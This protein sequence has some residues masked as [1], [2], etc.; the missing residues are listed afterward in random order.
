[1]RIADLVIAHP[2]HM[3]EPQWSEQPNGIVGNTAAKPVTGEAERFFSR[4]IVQLTFCRV[5]C[6]PL[7]LF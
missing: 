4:A 1:M 7:T 3:L 2:A 6:R 5:F